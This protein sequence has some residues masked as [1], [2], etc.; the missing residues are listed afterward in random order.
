MTVYR[1]MGVVGA[2]AWGLALA[3]AAASAGR[4]VALWGRDGE[5]MGELRLSRRSTRLPGVALAERVR[6]VSDLAALAGCEAILVATPAQPGLRR[7]EL[8]DPT[9][10]RAFGNEDAL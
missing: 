4:S 5:A 1:S 7:Q 9:T 6:V 8:K 10:G 3:N 2:G